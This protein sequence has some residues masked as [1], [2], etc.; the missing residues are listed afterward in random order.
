[1]TGTPRWVKVFGLVVVAAVIV[2]LVLQLTG[3][4]GRHGPGRHTAPTSVSIAP[5]A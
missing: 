2:L 1:M 3:V 4:G 5:T